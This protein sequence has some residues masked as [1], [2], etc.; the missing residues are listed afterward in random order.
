MSCE[1]SIEYYSRPFD[2]QISTIAYHSLF[3]NRDPKHFQITIEGVTY[4]FTLISSPDSD[5]DYKIKNIKDRK[6]LTNI[7]DSFSL[8]DVSETYDFERDGYNYYNI[9]NSNIS[10]SE[11]C[12]LL[13]RLFLGKS[14]MIDYH[15]YSFIHQVANVIKIQELSEISDL[16]HRACTE[17]SDQ[18]VF[19]YRKNV[20]YIKHSFKS[21]FFHFWTNVFSFFC[22]FGFFGRLL[23]TLWDISGPT[24]VFCLFL[25]TLI[26]FIT[27]ALVTLKDYIVWFFIV[28]IPF[29]LYSL[30]F[31]NIISIS[32]VEAMERNL[33]RKKT[34]FYTHQR[35]I[36]LFIRII[37]NVDNIP[38]YINIGKIHT[39]VHGVLFLTFT[40]GF[41]A[42][43][44][45]NKAPPFLNVWIIIFVFYVP[46]VRYFSLYIFYLIHSIVSLFNKPRRR[47]LEIGEFDNP[48]LC[49]FYLR[50]RPWIDFFERKGNKSKLAHNGRLL[51]RLIFSKT[52]Y[53]IL[54]TIAVIVYMCCAQTHMSAGQVLITIFIGIVM[55]FV[56]ATR[57]NFPFFWIYR[58]RG[59]RVTEGKIEEM[60]ENIKKVA[61]KRLQRY[62]RYQ[63]SNLSKGR[64]ETRNRKESQYL[65]DDDDNDNDNSLDNTESVDSQIEGIDQ[66]I[67]DNVLRQE[68]LQ[69]HEIATTWSKH[70][71]YL[72]WSSMILVCM[73]FVFVA[74]LVPMAGATAIKTSNEEGNTSGNFSAYEKSWL[75]EQYEKRIHKGEINHDGYDGYP[76]NFN[77]YKNKSYRN[78]FTDNTNSTDSSDGYNGTDSSDG[79]NGTD[80]SDG[81]N[82]T[83]SSDG[84]N[85]TDSTDG[86]DFYSETFRYPLS[87][88][89]YMRP[90]GLSIQEIAAL[91][92]L[93]NP[94][95]VNYSYSM[96]WMIEEFL[97][98]RGEVGKDIIFE[99]TPFKWDRSFQSSMTLTRFRKNPKLSVFAI[100]GT[101]NMQDMIADVEIWFAS[102][103]INVVIS[104]F[105]FVSIYSD[106]TIELIGVVTNLPR[107]AFKQFS[108]VEQYK[109]R[110]TDYIY[111]YLYGGNN[112]NETTNVE[113][114]IHINFHEDPEKTDENNKN[115]NFF[116]RIKN[117][118][119][120]K[121]SGR[122]KEL[123]RRQMRPNKKRTKTE[124]GFHIDPDEDIMIVGHSLGGGLAKIISLS[125]GIQ[126]VALS[127][128]GVRFIGS[129]YKNKTVKNVRETIVDIIPGQDLVAR[130]D[131]SLGTQIHIPCHRGLSCH[132]TRRLM[133]Q[134]AVMCNTFKRH[135]NWCTFYFD[136]KQIKEMFR[137]GEVVKIG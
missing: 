78:K 87:P 100:R 76:H 50:E 72:R 28:V 124:I 62:K 47:F 89:C 82:G 121:I 3:E 126:A 42:N 120:Q 114:D 67:K 69:W 129:F 1:C 77:R 9:S 93:S 26:L 95:P 37:F 14:I 98:E 79:Y 123:L 6:S 56:L 85:G 97:S 94:T 81:Y 135:E 101:S 92:V 68:A 122:K 70:Y 75:F 110:F 38:K 53:S 54:A 74:A 39:F 109:N 49:S 107:Y 48:Y 29:L 115:K 104:F 57:I 61:L 8:D 45:N 35:L 51:V 23:Q 36:S 43:L 19:Y 116:S 64:A 106:K 59:H 90:K 73:T 12:E 103:V 31:P 65:P 25:N 21:F 10:Q 133:C 15:N 34:F 131:M 136:D 102:V 99:N 83:D 118:I 44:M 60:R 2:Y 88:V 33:Y 137:I 5:L 32:I 16:T 125:T 13:R 108:L 96:R 134:I 91:T 7:M 11:K 22:F 119:F 66:D 20:F 112:G 58:I 111:E 105:P 41:I 17:Q 86:Y 132:S 55:I 80:S 113:N 18:F 63:D 4:D 128:P 27:M 71:K 52:T 127:G 46:L 40:C 24:M 130:V 117:N 84:Y 30:Y